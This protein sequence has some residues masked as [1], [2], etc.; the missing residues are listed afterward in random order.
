MK[1]KPQPFK[2]SISDPKRR[3]YRPNRKSAGIGPVTGS[4]LAKMREHDE[5]SWDK[6]AEWINTHYAAKPTNQTGYRSDRKKAGL[7]REL[8]QLRTGDIA[9]G[10]A[11]QAILGT[12]TREQVNN[13]ARQMEVQIGR[14]K[15]Y[16]V[17]NICNSIV[18]TIGWRKSAAREILALILLQTSARTINLMQTAYS[19]HR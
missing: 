18:I 4:H 5:I 12:L 7:A 16:T 14:S 10:S 19:P 15:G 8:S 1:A 3:G 9:L 13:V 2:P 11:M 17:A 6:I